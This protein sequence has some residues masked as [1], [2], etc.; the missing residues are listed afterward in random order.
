MA[1]LQQLRDRGPVGP[2]T[3]TGNSGQPLGLQKLRNSLKI[4]AQT[5]GMFEDVTSVLLDLL[6]GLHNPIKQHCQEQ[7]YDQ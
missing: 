4:V 1:R 7:C 3:L 2:D 6:D 5:S